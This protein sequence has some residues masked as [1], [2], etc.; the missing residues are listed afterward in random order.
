MESPKGSWINH[1][2]DREECEAEGLLAVVAGS[3]TTATVMR[4]TLLC[5]LSSPPTY[6]KLKTA[7]KDAVRQNT[8]S[9]PISYA[10]AKEIPYL[11]V[12]LIPQNPPRSCYRGATND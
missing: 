4:I 6:Q 7:V 8:V 1:G 3:E 11:R 9:E 12:S 5:I 2:F 10:E